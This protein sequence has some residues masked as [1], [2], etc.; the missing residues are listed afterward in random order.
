LEIVGYL[1]QN[2]IDLLGLPVSAGTPIYLGPTNI[3]HMKVKHPDDHAKYFSELK[4]IL[5]TPDFVVP[6]PVQG[7][8]QFIK[9]LDE[10][11]MVIVRA[12]GS[13]G[14]YYARSI[15]CMG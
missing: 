11:V 3:E 4:N 9:I 2:V 5:T 1:K 6:D 10:H 13:V 7:S 12:S 8:L 14:K 15:Y